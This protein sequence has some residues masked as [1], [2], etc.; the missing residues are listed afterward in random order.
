MSQSAVV[1]MATRTVMPLEGNGAMADWLVEYADWLRSGGMGEV[2]RIVMVTESLDGQLQVAAQ[3]RGALDTLTV[4]G[5]LNIAAARKAVG[6][7]W[8][9]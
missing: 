1:D 8:N 3:A 4:V 7:P 6:T 5:L 2:K 9:D